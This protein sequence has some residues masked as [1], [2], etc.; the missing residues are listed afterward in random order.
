MSITILL[1][2]QLSSTSAGGEM[3]RLPRG[4]WGHALCAERA[5]PANTAATSNKQP[6]WA[7]EQRITR[8]AV[9]AEA[10]RGGQRRL[11][12]QK[13]RRRRL[14]RPR[15]DP[16]QR[17]EYLPLAAVVPVAA[18]NFDLK[19]AHTRACVGAAAPRSR[20]GQSKAVLAR[21]KSVRRLVARRSSH[22]ASQSRAVKS[23]EPAPP[24][25]PAGRAIRDPSAANNTGRY[26]L[27]P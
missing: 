27:I 18:C 3:R 16:L 14:T 4:S 12:F 20:P 17:M 25:R 21:S 24:A 5:A 13:P 10:G 2:V 19:V 15:S 1:A 23:P 8:A 9:L 6:V 22:S 26:P 7:W 11:R